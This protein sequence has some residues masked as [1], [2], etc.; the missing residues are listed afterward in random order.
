MNAK[1]KRMKRGTAMLLSML[2]TFSSANLQTFAWGGG[3][4]QPDLS[5]SEPASMSNASRPQKDHNSSD[6]L[7]SG[8][9]AKKEKT[10]F[11]DFDGEEKRFDRSE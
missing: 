4:S 7:A 5:E 9:N 1:T 8:S 11:F 10:V 2:M 6:S 3:T